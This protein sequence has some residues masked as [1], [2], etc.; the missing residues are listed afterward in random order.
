MIIS[1]QSTIILRVI[2]Q[3]MQLVCFP[4]QIYYLPVN[5]LESFKKFYIF[6]QFHPISAH[7]IIWTFAVFEVVLV[8][9]VSR[10]IYE[11]KKDQC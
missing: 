7:F 4:L 11:M 9:F 2:Y 10:L 6:F 1:I 5:F 8:V 3:F